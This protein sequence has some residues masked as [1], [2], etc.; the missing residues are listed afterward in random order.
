VPELNGVVGQGEIAVI[1]PNTRTIV[2]TFRVSCEPAGLALGPENEAFIGCSDGPV[3]VINNRSGAHI[4]SFP[5]VGFADEVWFNHGD[6]HFF[7]ASGSNVV[8][9]KPTPVLGVIDAQT[10]QFDENVPTAVGDHSVAADQLRNHV[11]LPSQAT[12]SNPQCT[13]GCIEVFACQASH[14]GRSDM[15]GNGHGQGNDCQNHAEGD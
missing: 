1:D 6:G 8:N 13:N 7:S 10:K 15:A 2:K 4:R 11:F 12:T 14:G 5:R 9:G 3:Q